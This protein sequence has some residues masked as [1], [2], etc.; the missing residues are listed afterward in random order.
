[1]P[2]EEFLAFSPRT[3][4]HPGPSFSLPARRAAIHSSPCLCL[5]KHQTQL[6]CRSVTICLSP[7]YYRTWG[8]VPEPGGFGFGQA[9]ERCPPHGRAAGPPVGAGT[10]GGVA[11]AASGTR[12]Q[13][14]VLELTAIIWLFVVCCF[15]SSGGCFGHRWTWLLN[16]SKAWIRPSLVRE[17]VS[18]GESAATL[19]GKPLPRGGRAAASS[20]LLLPRHTCTYLHRS[21]RRAGVWGG[22]NLR[23]KM[24]SLRSQPCRLPRSA[25]VLS[26][27]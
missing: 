10:S 26:A 9:A 6:P 19:K 22:E 17:V 4:P 12:R 5:R 7:A 16:P 20:S 2:P 14:R 23:E 13:H 15:P 8:K 25:C 3:S 27:H 18:R 11:S 1:M 24:A 21:G